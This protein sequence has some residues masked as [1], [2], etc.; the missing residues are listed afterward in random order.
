MESRRILITGLSS[1]WGGRLAQRLER[2]PGVEAVVGVDAIEPRHELHRTEFVRLDAQPALLRRVISAAQIDTVVDTR[3][4]ADPLDASLDQVHEINV[5]GTIS[6][7]SACSGE[8]SP[9]RKVVFKSSSLYYGSEPDDPSFFTEEMKRPHP[10]RTSIERDIVRAEH[11]VDEFRARNPDKRVTVLRVAGGIG[12][13]LA[14]SHLALLNLPVVPSILGFD[15]RFQFIHEDDIVGALEHAVRNEIPGT[16]NVAGDG[17]LSL[18][19]IVSALGK[20]M[21][22]LLPPWGTDFAAAQLRRLGLRI[23]VEM[24]R[25]LRFGRGLDNRRLKATGFAYRYTTRESVLKL[26]AQQRL[27]PLLRS[28][29]EPYH[30]EREVEEFLRWSPSVRT[31]PPAG[32]ADGEDGG[33]PSAPFATYDEMLARELVDLIP[34]LEPGALAQLRR[35]E[36]AHRARRTVLDALDRALARGSTTR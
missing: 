13:E 25:E 14:A 33:A 28:G 35:Y 26:R 3:L 9:V 22:P 24:V 27:R 31:A 21:L 5:I 19:E 6:V 30:Y 36:A 1:Q 7:L 15:P 29:A 2:A 32:Q 18:S 12:E 34:S 23:P 4:L 10:P 11:A 17:V 16:Y 8:D 20:T